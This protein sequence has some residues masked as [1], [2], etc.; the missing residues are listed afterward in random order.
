MLAIQS[1]LAT[2]DLACDGSAAELKDKIIFIDVSAFGL[3]Q[4]YDILQINYISMIFMYAAITLYF[5]FR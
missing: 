4:N 5:T 2:P 1:R 3:F